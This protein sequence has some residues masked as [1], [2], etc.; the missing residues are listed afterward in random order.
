MRRYLA[1][2]FIPLMMIF[3]MGPIAAD[4]TASVAMAQ[5]RTLVMPA[6][7]GTGKDTSHTTGCPTVTSGIWTFPTCAGGGGACS[8]LTPH[9]VWFDSSNN[10]VAD[11]LFSDNGTGLSGG[12]QYTGDGI[13]ATASQGGSYVFTSTDTSSAG[14]ANAIFNL[15]GDGGQRGNQFLVNIDTSTFTGPYNVNT[16]TINLYTRGSST[17]GNNIYLTSIANP[18]ASGSGGIVLEATGKVLIKSDVNDGITLQSALNTNIIGTQ[19]LTIRGGVAPTTRIVNT[20]PYTAGTDGEATDFANATSGNLVINLPSP[21]EG[22][23]VIVKKTDATANTVTVHTSP[24]NID[25]S[26]N[27]ILTTQYQAVQVQFSNAANVWYVIGK[28]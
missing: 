2:L 5:T 19:P 13:Y 3:F 26:A 18:I 7:G 20:T 23:I 12:L 25:G 24:T 14:G 15:T 28:N 22:Q 27:Y 4:Y 17:N 16:G 11:P 21:V 8:G 10:C 6:Q 1:S 9:I